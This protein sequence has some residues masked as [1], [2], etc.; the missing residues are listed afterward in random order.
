MSA[1]APR[2]RARSALSATFNY[3]P[4]DLVRRDPE[5]QF[6]VHRKAAQATDLGSLPAYAS[7]IVERAAMASSRSASTRSG[8]P[9]EARELRAS[10]MFQKLRVARIVPA[11]A[12]PTAEAPGPRYRP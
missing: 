5:T 12:W 2:S 10:L 4:G 11:R 6:L 7:V 9:R 8:K 1:M 3:L